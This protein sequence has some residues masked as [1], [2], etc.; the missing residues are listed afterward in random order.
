[1]NRIKHFIFFVILAFAL[2]FSYGGCVLVFTTGDIEKKPPPDTADSSTD[3]SGRNDLAVID[4]TNADDLTEGAL[5]G[6]ITRFKTE[7][8]GFAQKSLTKQSS[9][10]WP[11]RLPL[12]LKDSVQKIETAALSVDPLRPAVETKSGILQGGCGG[13]LLYS[14]DFVRDA[15]VFDGSI[16]FQNYCFRGI[17]IS[18][19]TGVDG[20]YGSGTGK[21]ST[22]HFSFD[23]LSDG[24]IALAGELSLDLMQQKPITA[25][26]SAYSKELASG[27]VYWIKDYSM[28]IAEFIGFTEIEIFGTFY[29][30]EHGYVESTTLEPFIVHY[31]DEWPTS[32][33]LRIKGADN[34]RAQLTALNQV[35]LSIEA[36]TDGNGGFEWDSGVIFW[37]DM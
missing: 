30:P 25:N 10:F 14:M 35:H 29:H 37:D 18:G 7:S 3:Y 17:T 33:L 26:F 31:E 23:E 19:E 27:Q 22:S 28:N 13:R 21:F 4:S 12:V 11:L 9:V 34:T 2:P 16:S 15:N 32:G 24:Q 6:G 36:D 1:M 20:T 8:A 5:S